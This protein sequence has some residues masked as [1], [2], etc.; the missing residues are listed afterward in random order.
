MKFISV[1]PLD[2][3]QTKEQFL[4]NLGISGQRIKK[5]ELKRKELQ[6]KVGKEEK[7]P[8][9]LINHNQIASEYHGEGEGA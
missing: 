5:S 4:K 9:D 8:L 2:S 6:R 1:C 3:E 7:Y